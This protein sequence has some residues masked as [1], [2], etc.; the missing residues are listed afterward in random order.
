M[1]QKAVGATGLEIRQAPIGLAFRFKGL[2]SRLKGGE[3]IRTIDVFRHLQG[4][5]E[6]AKIEGQAPLQHGGR[7]QLHLRS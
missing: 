4:G 5:A 2:P 1:V 6:H 7:P 3:G